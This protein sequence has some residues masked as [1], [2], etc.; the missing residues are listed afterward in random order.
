MAFPKSQNSSN[1]MSNK[2]GNA[3]GEDE[4]SNKGPTSSSKTIGVIKGRLSYSK[5]NISSLDQGVKTA[6]GSKLEQ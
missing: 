2:F 4:R 1:G 3:I 6:R 5:S